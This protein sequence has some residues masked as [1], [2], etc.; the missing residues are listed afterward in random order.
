MWGPAGQHSTKNK[1]S[2]RNPSHFLDDAWVSPHNGTDFFYCSE[3]VRRLSRTA[4][5]YCTSG[6]CQRT[7]LSGSLFIADFPSSY[8]KNLRRRTKDRIEMDSDRVGSLTLYAN[9]C[10]MC[11]I[12][13]KYYLGLKKDESYHDLRLISNT[14]LTY[15]MIYWFKY[16]TCPRRLNVSNERMVLSNF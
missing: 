13:K 5:A 3:N 12:S 1:R 11:F 2:L 16:V 15:I 6:G 10:Q 4:T 7:A 14:F 8:R 9:N